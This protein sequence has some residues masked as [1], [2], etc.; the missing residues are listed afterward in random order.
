MQQQS[1]MTSSHLAT[2]VSLSIILV[3]AIYLV[4]KPDRVLAAD[5]GIKLMSQAVDPA[6]EPLQIVQAERS[7]KQT[8]SQK[9][10]V[11]ADHLVILFHGIRG[12]GA[13]MQAVGNS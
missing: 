10:M 9:E 1:P 7:Q 8:A 13:V 11:R 5:R 12:R 4:A 2:L 3:G 6:G